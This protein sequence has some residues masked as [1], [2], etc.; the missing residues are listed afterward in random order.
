MGFLLLQVA[1][2]IIDQLQNEPNMIEMRRLPDDDPIK[3]RGEPSGLEI[4]QLKEIT[5]TKKPEVPPPQMRSTGE[6]Q[7]IMR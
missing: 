3:I 2:R 4:I 5:G 7:P 1:Q 6:F